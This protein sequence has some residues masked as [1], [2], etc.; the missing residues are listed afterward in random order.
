MRA[1]AKNPS[2]L[3]PVG[4]CGEAKPIVE[5]LGDPAVPPGNVAEMYATMVIGHGV[6]VALI[7]RPANELECLARSNVLIGVTPPIDAAG[8]RFALQL[9]YPARIRPDAAFGEQGE[10]VGPAPLLDLPR[11]AVRSGRT[12]FDHRGNIYRSLSMP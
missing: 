1:A 3:D 2:D 7:G 12:R 6:A 10:C 9:R 5:R 8:G 11:Y 4:D